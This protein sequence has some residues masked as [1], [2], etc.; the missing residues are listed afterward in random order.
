MQQTGSPCD[1][2]V[3]RNMLRGFRRCCSY[4][5]RM[6]PQVLQR[7]RG[8]QG[9]E[10]SRHENLSRRRYS[11][12]G[13][14]VHDPRHWL[15]QAEARRVRGVQQLPH[16]TG[17]DAAMACNWAGEAVSSEVRITW[18][19]AFGMTGSREFTDA[20]CV[21]IPAPYPKKCPAHLWPEAGFGFGME[22]RYGIRNRDSLICRK[23]DSFI[24]GVA[25]L[26]DFGGERGLAVDSGIVASVHF[27]H[28]LEESGAPGQHS[29][30]PMP[31]RPEV[32]AR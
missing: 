10:A 6:L 24:E 29:P 13:R 22:G 21:P 23:F 3:E 12:P 17:S 31:G 25:C 19:A 16:R 26:E 27:C 1:I 15:T 5:L 7:L 14:S 18:S 9:S 28:G 30:A 2:C 4:H 20:A 8:E 32:S 11:K